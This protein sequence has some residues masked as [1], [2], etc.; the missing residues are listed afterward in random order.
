MYARPLQDYRRAIGEHGADDRPDGSF[1]AHLL[2]QVVLRRP[3]ILRGRNTWN[4]RRARNT[5]FLS[6]F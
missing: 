4:I 6:A 3:N 5:Q 1:I 2:D